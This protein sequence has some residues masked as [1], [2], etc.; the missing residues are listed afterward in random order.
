MRGD[1][2]NQTARFRTGPAAMKAADLRVGRGH[3]QW[4]KGAR[5]HGGLWSSVVQAD[6][7][8]PLAAPAFIVEATAP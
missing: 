4:G 8:K 3:P 5:R 6:F 7:L 2:A 1:E